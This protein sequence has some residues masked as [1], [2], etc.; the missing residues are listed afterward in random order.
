MGCECFGVLLDCA[1]AFDP[2]L[3][4]AFLQT[5]QSAKSRFCELEGYKAAI[6]DLNQTAN[7]NQ[8]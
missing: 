5:G 3:P 1:A 8:I 7:S 2:F 6:G 4:V